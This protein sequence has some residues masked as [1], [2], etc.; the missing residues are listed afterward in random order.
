MYTVNIATKYAHSPKAAELFDVVPAAGEARMFINRGHRDGNLAL[1]SVS[2]DLVAISSSPSL[3]SR[4]WIGSLGLVSRCS[5]SAAS[6]SSR[7]VI[8]VNKDVQHI[9][10]CWDFTLCY[11]R[12]WGTVGITDCWRILNYFV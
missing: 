4:V 12:V 2:I 5:L 7:S 6:L 11:I 8:H 10:L 9:L 1:S 3:F